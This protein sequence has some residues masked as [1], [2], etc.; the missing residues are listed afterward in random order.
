LRQLLAT[1]LGPAQLLLC[2]ITQPLSRRQPLHPPVPE[3]L[4][5]GAGGIPIVDWV[6]SFVQGEPVAAAA[7]R[8]PT[9]LFVGLNWECDG[10]Q[11]V[12]VSRYRAPW[13]RSAVRLRVIAERG[14]VTVRLPDCISWA[15][16]DGKHVHRRRGDR[17]VVESMLLQ[18][19][20]T[21]RSGAPPTP[22]LL[23]TRRALGWLRLARRSL[24]EGRRVAVQ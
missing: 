13:V 5:L 21:L 14:T 6:A 7:A 19:A 1:E 4:L 17:P 18:F 3:D 22:S 2:E 9:G 16:A 15:A 23:D 20:E 24:A 12:H 8:S 11:N 10:K